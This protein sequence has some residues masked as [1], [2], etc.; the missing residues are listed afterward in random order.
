MQYLRCDVLEI[1]GILASEDEATSEIVL[2]V[3][4]LVDPDQILGE[5]DISISQ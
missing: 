1:H 4:Q 5:N 2:K 3:A